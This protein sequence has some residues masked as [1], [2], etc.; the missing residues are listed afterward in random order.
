VP[1][2]L[3]SSDIDYFLDP[4]GTS[5]LHTVYG[6][7]F[8]VNGLDSTAGYYATGSVSNTLSYGFLSD[9]TGV[10]GLWV[11]NSGDSGVYIS[12]TG[13]HGVSVA[14]AAQDDFY[15]AGALDDGLEIQSPG[16]NGIEVRGANDS[17]IYINGAY[18]GM[19]IASGGA[20]YGLYAPGVSQTGVF[21]EAGV[22]GGYFHETTN[23]IEARIAFR[24]GGVN[25]GI[26]SNGTKSFV[27]QHPTD[28][29][30]SIIYAALEG[31]EA[32]TY[33]R[34]TAQLMNGAALVAL[35]EHFSLGTEKEGLTVQVTPRG[36]CRGLYVAEV[37][38]TYIVVRE[39][40]G[41]KSNAR[42]DFFINGVRTGYTGFQVVVDNAQLDLDAIHP[43][44]A[45]PP[46]PSGSG[47]PDTEGGEGN[48]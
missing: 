38:T 19:E 10:N 16:N 9:N 28:A 22:L 31:G 29:S 26:L 2:L 27:Q 18:I 33:Y 41:G 15:G 47:Q 32:G 17:G 34:G 11:V 14:S 1:R 37:T 25:Y 8:G 21:A 45:R 24:N 48:E 43:A 39:L 7:T 36:D 35:P 20:T 44:N 42:F 46:Q 5:N 30:K 6:N 4:G 23:N 12:N 3:D 13:A 40:Q